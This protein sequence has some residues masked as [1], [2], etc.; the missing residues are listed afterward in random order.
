MDL[1]H[2][3]RASGAQLTK[4]SKLNLA[5]QEV[6]EAGNTYVL[7]FL[8]EE[9]SGYRILSLESLCIALYSAIMYGRKDV[10]ELLLMAGADVNHPDSNRPEKSPLSAAIRKKDSKLA[11]QLLVA[12]ANVKFRGYDYGRFTTKTVLPDVVDWGYHSLIQDIINAGAELD[13]PGILSSKTALFVAVEKRSKEVVRL[14]IDAGANVNASEAVL[15]G[16]NHFWLHLGIMTY[17][18]FDIF[19][20]LVPIQTK[21]HFI[22]LSLVV[23]SW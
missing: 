9:E 13:A 11:K 2:D 17:R 20:S 10:V 3:L 5:I 7:R 15:S 23:K 14:L 16:Q 12:G 18:W 4:N 21:C 6:I 19:L 1:I 8:L 22:L